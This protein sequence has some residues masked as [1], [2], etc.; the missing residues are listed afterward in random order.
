M[1][2][3]ASSL[4]F[5]VA[6]LG[7]QA[8]S[9]ALLPYDDFRDLDI[10]NRVIGVDGLSGTLDVTGDDGDSVKFDIA[11]FD[12]FTHLVTNV[13]MAFTFYE[14]DGD[15][16]RWARVDFNLGDAG[17]FEVP[18]VSL[19]VG[20]PSEI[21]SFDYVFDSATLSKDVSM[22]LIADVQTDGKIEWEVRLDEYAENVYLFAAALGVEAHAIASSEARLRPVPDTGATAALLGVCV[23]GMAVFRRRIA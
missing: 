19:G 15:L 18:T 2:I 1:K 12:P 3:L 8:A 23:F 22:K 10:V 7:A 14:L 5:A 9:A 4:A 6:F 13:A 17:E 20:V 16:R 21:F 11:G